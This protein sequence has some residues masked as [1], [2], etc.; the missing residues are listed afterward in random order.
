MDKELKS[1]IL[2]LLDELEYV[3]DGDGLQV[4]DEDATRER[5]AVVREGLEYL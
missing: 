2:A 3:I 4:E 1:A 5:L